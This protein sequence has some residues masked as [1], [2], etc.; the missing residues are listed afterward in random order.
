MN[1]MLR[2]LFLQWVRVS[3]P[4]AN[5]ASASLHHVKNLAIVDRRACKRSPEP[6]F[7][8]A[9]MSTVGSASRSADKVPREV[10]RKKNAAR[11]AHL[12]HTKPSVRENKFS[13]ARKMCVLTESQS[14]NVRYPRGAP[15]CFHVSVMVNN[16]A[17]DTGVQISLQ[18]P[19]FISFG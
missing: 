1:R 17:V 15:A 5:I 3:L 10:A 9:Q 18:D 16:A 8:I 13:V 6:F 14:T 19:G 12:N 11:T 7:P 4:A 2:V